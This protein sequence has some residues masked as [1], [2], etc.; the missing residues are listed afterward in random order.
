MDSH[1]SV[2]PF[3]LRIQT[4]TLWRGSLIQAYCQQDFGAAL[5]FGVMDFHALVLYFELRIRTLKLWRGR[6]IRE[7]GLPYFDVAL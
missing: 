6:L 7:R 4:P 3:E 2:L 1:A 5:R